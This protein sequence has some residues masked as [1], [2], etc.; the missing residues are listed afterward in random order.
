MLPPVDTVAETN[1]GAVVSVVDAFVT[2]SAVEAN[3]TASLPTL[4]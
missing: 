2:S 3:E 4:S 1:V